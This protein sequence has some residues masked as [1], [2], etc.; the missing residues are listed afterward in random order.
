MVLGKVVSKIELTRPP[1]EAKQSEIFSVS[2]PVESHVH[3]LCPLWLD[4][5]VDNTFS[6]EVVYSNKCR[7]LLVFYFF[8]DKTDVHTFLCNDTE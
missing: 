3:R 5:A 8:E 7:G 6:C 1:I 2:K 4:L